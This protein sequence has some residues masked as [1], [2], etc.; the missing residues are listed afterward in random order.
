MYFAGQAGMRSPQYIGTSKRPCF[1]C[2]HFLRSYGGFNVTESHGEVHPLWTVPDSENYTV[3][4]MR[5]IQRALQSTHAVLKDALKVAKARGA[6]HANASQMPQSTIN[7]AVQPLPT[8]TAS[9]LTSIA[10]SRA[11]TDLEVGSSRD[12]LQDACQPLSLSDQLPSPSAA[13]PKAPSEVDQLSQIAIGMRQ[14]KN[15]QCQSREHTQIE[16][17]DQHKDQ[18]KLPDVQEE[19]AVDCVS[20]LTNQAASAFSTSENESSETSNQR[21]IEGRRRYSSSELRKDVLQRIDAQEPSFET[22]SKAAP[23][24]EPST[25]GISSDT[26]SE[27]SI[28]LS[29]KGTS[30]AKSTMTPSAASTVVID[31]PQTDETLIEPDGLALFISTEGLPERSDGAPASVRVIDYGRANM[32][33]DMAVDLELL[34]DEVVTV[35][36]RA[37]PGGCKQV[38]LRCSGSRFYGLAFRWPGT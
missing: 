28:D 32:S 29:S 20:L 23:Q 13:L 1:L 19:S 38:V 26:K 10:I 22:P 15:R 25:E 34:T 4:Q 36:A 7:L 16:T 8:P 2:F 17:I 5:S 21:R 31:L 35:A 33:A 14:S 11:Q 30:H 3:L 12:T 9:T 27:T 6:K 37:M 24:P 18:P